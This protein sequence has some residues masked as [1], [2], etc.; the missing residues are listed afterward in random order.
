MPLQR[1]KKQTVSCF[2]PLFRGDAPEYNDFIV[3]WNTCG[4]RKWKLLLHISL[5]PNWRNVSL[6]SFEEGK[7]KHFKDLFFL[8]DFVERK[9]KDSEGQIWGVIFLSGLVKRGNCLNGG[10]C[11]DVCDR[12]G[13]QDRLWCSW[14]T[15]LGPSTVKMTNGWKFLWVTLNRQWQYI[16]ED[17]FFFFFLS[18]CRKGLN[19]VMLHNKNC[20]CSLAHIKYTAW[21]IKCPHLLLKLNYALT[22]AQKSR[23][24]DD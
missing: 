12:P 24:Q 13:Q 19:W 16:R 20:I 4:R 11:E 21:M 5:G 9:K 2:V 1:E 10:R 22:Y 18:A 14:N 15:A 23:L 7:K 17:F 3:Q 6:P 8:V